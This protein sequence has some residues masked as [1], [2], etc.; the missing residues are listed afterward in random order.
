[1][2]CKEKML[3][4]T[5]SLLWLT[6]L[7]TLAH[8]EAVLVTDDRWRFSPKDHHRNLMVA[9]ERYR[10]IPSFNGLQMFSINECGMYEYPNSDY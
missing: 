6:A 10:F 9:R 1:M 5:D 8:R 3:V 7:W 4:N 2:L